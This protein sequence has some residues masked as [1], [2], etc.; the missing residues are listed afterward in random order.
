MILEF[1]EIKLYFLLN[2]TCVLQAG[3]PPQWSPRKPPRS[4]RQL[5]WFFM[6]QKVCNK[7]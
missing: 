6:T 4:P 3:Q 7:S 5:H 2:P 1:G